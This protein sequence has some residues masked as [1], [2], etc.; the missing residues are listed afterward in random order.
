[1]LPDAEMRLAKGD[2]L[3][4][5]G[6][7]EDIRRWRGEVQLAL[8]RPASAEAS[9]SVRVS[10]ALDR[11]LARKLARQLRGALERS[12]TRFVLAFESLGGQHEV[13]R[14]SRALSGYGDRVLIV[15]GE[16]LRELL[17]CEQPSA[18]PAAA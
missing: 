14:L 16:G 18:S 1:V 4:V 9:I 2:D 8:Y 15:I 12:R 5:I 11:A 7:G 13:E 3:I 6:T 17:R 10:A